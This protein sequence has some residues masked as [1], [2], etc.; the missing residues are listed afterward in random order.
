VGL[1][2]RD[3]NQL[4]VNPLAPNDWDWFVLDNVAYRG[5][6]ISIVW[7]RTGQRYGRGPG[8]SLWSNGREVARSDSLQRIVADL[9]AAPALEPVDRPVNLAVNNGRGPFP[10]IS[11][12][13]SAPHAPPH[14][15]IDGHAWYDPQPP[16][17]W[18]AGAP[19]AADT[20][21]LYFGITRPVDEV[22]LHFI[23]DGD[24]IRPPAAYA[25]FRWENDAWVPLE[26][27]ERLPAAPE[28]R[29]V[30]RV[31]LNRVETERLR[32]VLTHRD[33]ARSGLTELETWT[34]AA[35]PFPAP[36][37]APRNL[38]VNAAVSASYVAPG[39]RAED[40]NDTRVAY[41]RYSRN[42]WSA[43]GSPN[44]SDW[45]A[46]DFAVP[47]KVARVDVH[48][49]DSERGLAPPT[50]YTVQAWDGKSWKD[51]RVRRV[52]PEHPQGW[53]QNT[54]YVE[55]VETSRVRVVFVH[56][57]PNATAVSE[58]VILEEDR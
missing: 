6:R 33:G 13:S 48:I 27:R 56:A 32:V 47:H 34:R 31:L 3:D 55:P 40:V 28:G 4:E 15:L 14:Y 11:A 1:R 26:E 52:T 18:I 8:L 29:R 36:T 25:L 20:L 44:E 23:D 58:I 16:N 7:D 54:V 21:D 24:S 51:A 38:A 41:T 49:V 37:T 45:I 2:P 50:R 22:A 53:A 46:I 30:N 43:L 35:G 9:G 39:S 57:R 5:R 17:R 12:S 42:R 10:M 19:N